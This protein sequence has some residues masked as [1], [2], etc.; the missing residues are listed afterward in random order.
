MRNP[1]TRT[2]FQALTK[3]VGA[4]ESFTSGQYGS[5][6]EY[7]ISKTEIAVED[8]LRDGSEQRYDRY[9]YWIEQKAPPSGLEGK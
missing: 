1:I 8:C 7:R 6:R 4:D 3:N 5:R 2:E 9:S